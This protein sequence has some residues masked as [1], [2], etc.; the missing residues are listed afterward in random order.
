MDKTII[1]GNIISFFGAVCM[2]ISCS[3]KDKTKSFIFLGAQ[4]I[5]LVISSLVFASYS[6][7]V[8]MG[9]SAIRCY[10]VIKDLYT[11]KVMYLF[12]VLILVLGLGVNSKGLLGVIPVA[13]SLEFT[14]GIFL[15]PS[16]RGTK[17][18]LMI[19]L[20]MLSVYALIIQDYSS[21]I[22]WGINGI[23][24]M[25]TVIRM[26]LPKKEGIA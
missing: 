9:L 5:F 18:A 11:K 15:F 8:T 6:A 4:N 19:N 16:A 23:M 10:L 17:A 24:S 25:I 21:G 1:I 26:S 3:S 14:L 12:V 13:A 7:M 2:F 20:A 22:T